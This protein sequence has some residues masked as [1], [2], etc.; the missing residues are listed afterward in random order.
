MNKNTKTITKIIMIILITL[1]ILL[2]LPTLSKASNTST[3]DRTFKTREYSSN[4]SGAIKEFTLLKLDKNSF[5]ELAWELLNH[6]SIESFDNDE[7]MDCGRWNKDNCKVTLGVYNALYGT[8]ERC[9][10][11]SDNNH[12]G[13]YEFNLNDEGLSYW[14]REGWYLVGG[15]VVGPT[16][17]VPN[18]FCTHPDQASNK[19]NGEDSEHIILYKIDIYKDK[20][21]CHVNNDGNHTSKNPSEADLEILQNWCEILYKATNEV[22]YTWPS[23]LHIPNPEPGVRTIP[24][25]IMTPGSQPDSNDKSSPS[26]YDCQLYTV[27]N[28]EAIEKAIEQT[29]GIKDVDLGSSSDPLKDF[30]IGQNLR[31]NIKPSSDTDKNYHAR[32]YF[33][34]DKTN[35]SQARMVFKVDKEYN[36]N[37]EL[38]LK[39]E[40][41]KGTA[42]KDAKITLTAG[43]NV[44]SISNK[45]LTSDKDGNFD[46][47]TVKAE[48]NTGTFKI[49][50]KETAPTGYLGLQEEVT[51]TVSYDTKTGKVTNIDSSNTTN[52]PNV[53]ENANVK[54]ITIKNKRIINSLTLLKLDSETGKTLAGAEFKITLTNVESIGSYSVG[55]NKSGSITITGIKT[56]SDGNLK[57][58]DL[59]INDESKPVKITIEETE[60]PEGYKKIN[61][62]IYITLE[63][64][65]NGDYKVCKITKDDTVTEDECLASTN[66]NLPTEINISLTIKN[67]PISIPLTLKKIDHNGQPVQGATITLEGN[68]NVKEIKDKTKLTSDANGSF[69]SVKVYPNKNN[70]ELKVKIKE[71]D[72]NGFS[73]IKD[74]ILT[75][76]YNTEDGKVTS[77]T[78]DNEDVTIEVNNDVNIV[79][80]KDRPEIS[81]LSLEKTDSLTGAKLKGA[82]FDVTITD[83]KSV[84]GTAASESGTL[85]QKLTTDDNGQLKLEDIVFA[86]KKGQISVT[87]KETKAP[88]TGSADYYYRAIEPITF[89]IKY[90]LKDGKATFTLLDK[91]GKEAANN[92][93]SID[94]NTVISLK[95][96]QVTLS[97]KNVPVIDLSG[98]VWLD[99]Q[100]GV[101]DVAGPNGK[102]DNGEPGMNDVI[103]SLYSIKDKK[104]IA[105]QRTATV[106]GLAGQYKFENVE[107]TNEGYKIYF[108]YDGINY[109]ETKATNTENKQNYGTDSKADEVKR[110]E[111]NDKFKTISKNQSNGG[112]KLGYD[113]NSQEHTS[114][115]KTTIDGRNPAN[116]EFK[117]DN[118]DSATEFRM[119]AE[120]NDTYKVTTT[121]IDCGLVKKEFDLSISTAAKSARLEINEKSIEYTE[122]QISDGEMDD[123]DLDNI[124][125]NKS[126]DNQNI[127]DNLYLYQSDYN[128][129]I[130]DYITD[131][132][133]DNSVNGDNGADA[134]KDGNP[135]Y[136]NLKELEAYVTYNVLQ[137]AHNYVDD[138]TVNEFVYYYDSVYTPFIIDGKEIKEGTGEYTG[139][140]YNFKIEKNKITFTSNNNT[141][142]I[143]DND[144]SAPLRV[145]LFLEFRVNKN[146]EGY[147]EL[148]DSCK[149]VVE[150]T[151]Y[152]TDDGGWIDVDSAPENT[153]IQFNQDGTPYINNFDEDD[154]HESEGLKIS[155]K[156]ES[157]AI[158]GTVFEDTDGDGI[159]NSEN[160]AVNDAIVQLIELKDLYTE[161]NEYVGT[162]EYIWQET[163]SGSNQV[164]TTTRNGYEG[165]GYEN[166]VTAGSGMFEFKDFIP[167]NYI[168]RYIYGD[169]RTYDIT[170]DEYKDSA[171]NIKKYNGQD[172]KST[173]DDKYTEEWFNA[174]NYGNNASV[175]RD[176]EARRLEVM[177]YS[178]MIDKENGTALERRE[179]DDLQKTWMAAETS[180][181]NVPIDNSS[182][183]T[184]KNTVTFENMN[185]G[186]VERPKTD[187][188]LEKH[189]TGLKITPSG[190][191][192]QPIV[193]ARA[194]IGDILGSNEIKTTGVTQGLATNKS[195]RDNR[196]FWQV[197]TDIEELTQGAQLEVEYTYVIK[198]NGTEDYLLKALVDEYKRN[199]EGYSA[200]LTNTAAGIKD[201]LKGHTNKYGEY[202]GQY[203]YNGITDGCELVPTRIEA[204]GLEEA[205]NN[206][207]SFDDGTSGEDF[208][209]ASES[210]EKKVYDTNGAPKTENIATVIQNSSASEFLTPD[211]NT[212]YSK[213]VILRKI[214]SAS[215]G[216]DLGSNMPSYIAE[217]LKY[218]NAAGRRDMEIVPAN[219]SYVHSDDNEMTLNNSWLYE[220]DGET[221]ETQDETQIPEGA[222]NI[223][224]ANEEDEFWGESII[225]TKPT[226]EDRITGVQIAIIT[227]SSI[228]ALGVGIVLIKKFAL[229]K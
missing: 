3:F 227:I 10:Y 85:S 187:I 25:N 166:S 57:V 186:L 196:G 189:I 132:S 115:L 98:M 154:V 49:K 41:F 24:D 54:I 15:G 94:D 172:Y 95:G 104:V 67:I 152:S 39:K 62:K 31:A 204:N 56:D 222:T 208:K 224:E 118:Y 19:Y 79:T 35:M 42:L 128:Y 32:I 111:F 124:L 14:T 153:D 45:Q 103:V 213:K 157:R 120:T 13:I 165:T 116:E 5:Y 137:E 117:A 193:D 229:K 170:L 180:K 44:K 70:G 80:V 73:E 26:L 133:I 212:D 146:K 112:A 155:L 221:Y 125:D 162:Y 126:S 184:E 177:A 8:T 7:T 37:V 217:I 131:T 202:L 190:T 83:V 123:L 139:E 219:L 55:G 46:K 176:N 164:K 101:K 97:V 51:L 60:A 206:D 205:L 129:R 192:V 167:G 218:S 141:P 121:G 107:M 47:V 188:V 59:V 220:K 76:K 201:G 84:G 148:K 28:I 122:Q 36:P 211:N 77:I 216:G 130:K 50:L 20:V 9:S 197:A 12:D 182:E 53:S 64:E 96:D 69:G 48:K 105:A 11:Y 191:G 29:T 108:S 160:G 66:D 21:T 225:I 90:A 99:G 75:V 156:T 72:I 91:D 43:D 163:R 175:A 226:G 209:K 181:L 52:V 144:S 150:I 161:D 207:L 145:E 174:S 228:A 6:D 93:L 159:L 169:G 179:K 81:Q 138:S 135:D 143:E 61:G 183:P 68:D 1:G 134:N 23:K 63:K 178:S 102:N 87:I 33:I 200:Y 17:Y 2:V 147:V 89:N 173:K 223:R 215:T 109:I 18:I 158:S 171:E 106:D 16:Y 203:Y 119:S 142:K 88:E 74:T 65:E 100:S 210:V 214:L 127:I 38:S 34:F 92:Q 113:Y 168:I 58:N 22:Q 110:T 4:V 140:H 71:A 40:D 82:E 195:T 136:A 194:S 78:S 185:F 151:K 198:N 27:E 30:A 86:D 114:T 149:N 199:P